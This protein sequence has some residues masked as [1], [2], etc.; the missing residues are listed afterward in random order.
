[1]TN[2][3]NPLLRMQN[4]KKDFFGNQVLTDINFTLGEGEVLGLC[5][6]NGAGK[7]TLMKILFGMDVIRETGGYSGDILLNGQKVEFNTPFDALEAGIGMVH[8]EFSLIPGFTAT[9]NIL[10]NREPCKKN[11]VSEVF[12]DRL[13]TLD[14]KE[15]DRRSAAAIEKMGVAIDA[16]MVISDMPVGH[17]QFTEIA[18]ELSKDQLKLLILDEP[19]A[20][21]TEKEAEAL[22]ESIRGMAARGISVIFITHRLHEILAV[23]DKVVVMRDG[24]VVRDVSAKETSVEDITKWMVGRDV[25]SAV[26]TEAR[27]NEG[28]RTIM[29]I[30]NLW[31]DMPGETVRDVSL[32]IREGEILGIGGLAGQGKLGIPNG[33]M[34]LYEAGGKVTFNGGEI[35]LNN[36]RKCLDSSLAFVSEDRREVGLLLDE[37]LEWNVAFPAMQIQEKFLRKLLGGL[38][39]WRDEKGIHE[40][41]QKYIDELQ[42]K[43]TSSKQKAKELSGGNQQKVCLAK[44]FALEPKFLFVSEPTRGID[45]GAKALVLEALKKFNRDSGVT[46]VMISSELEELRQTCDR[47]AIVS[48]GQVAGIL[49]ASASSEEFGLLMVS[50]VI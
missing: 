17:K 50:K 26:V 37:S 41:T 6:E 38:V 48:G 12:G 34:G 23:C 11:I 29:S 40:V 16:E 18:R 45:V 21:L 44:A 14:Y 24:Y 3:V 4:I 35:P 25:Q 33:V 39:K 49:P 31:V 30:Q 47:I 10:L 27:T 19:T 13:N 36:P 28:A 9:E 5:G 42:I 43:C 32:D 20:V 15:M 46:V 7:S 2:N 8:Q 1:M 22:L